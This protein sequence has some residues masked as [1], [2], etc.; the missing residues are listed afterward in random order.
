[1]FLINQAMVD[2]PHRNCGFDSCARH[3]GRLLRADSADARDQGFR[4][5]HAEQRKLLQKPPHLLLLPQ[6]PLPLR[7]PQRHLRP[8]PQAK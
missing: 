1:M 8:A 2:V 4:Q 6:P 5:D 7:L 3:G